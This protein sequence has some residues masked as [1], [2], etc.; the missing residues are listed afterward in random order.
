MLAASQYQPGETFVPNPVAGTFEVISDARL[1]IH[2]AAGWYMAADPNT[3]DTVR[4]GYLN[5]VSTPT[6]EQ[7][8]GFNVDGVEYK[9]RLDAA[10]QV[11]DHRGL[12]SNEG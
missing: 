6:M 5:G 9:I 10:A 11:F 12:Y 2:N 1:D 4:V 3:C 7:R 8:D